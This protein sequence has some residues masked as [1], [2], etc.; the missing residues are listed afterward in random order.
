MK[1]IC[2]ITQSESVMG[3]PEVYRIPDGNNLYNHLTHNWWTY[4]TLLRPG[5][6]YAVCNGWRK[7]YTIDTKGENLDR[8]MIITEANGVRYSTFH[9]DP[10]SHKVVRTRSKT[11]KKI[12]KILLA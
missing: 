8:V 3:W 10:L 2:L 1:N 9:R 4:C 12:E 11:I 5:N 7:I 6:R